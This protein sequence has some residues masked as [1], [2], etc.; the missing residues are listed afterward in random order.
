MAQRSSLRRMRTHDVTAPYLLVLILYT[1]LLL[2]GASIGC[3]CISWRTCPRDEQHVSGT[4]VDSDVQLQKRAAGRVCNEPSFGSFEPATTDDYNSKA[5][6]LPCPWMSTAAGDALDAAHAPTDSIISQ[7]S[8][9]EDTD[10]PWAQT[11]GVRD[12][13]QLHKRM[14][15]CRRDQQRHGRTSRLRKRVGWSPD[16]EWQVDWHL[17][18][19]GALVLVCTWASVPL[20]ESAGACLGEKLM[21][22]LVWCIVCAACAKMLDAWVSNILLAATAVSL[23]LVRDTTTTSDHIVSCVTTVLLVSMGPQLTPSKVSNMQLIVKGLEQTLVLTVDASDTAQH[24]RQAILHQCGI[25]PE[26][27]YLVLSGKRLQD[28]TLAACGILPSAHPPTVHM[29]FRMRGGSPPRVCRNYQLGRCRGNCSLDHP[30]KVC[31]YEAAAD[32]GCRNGLDCTYSHN[33]KDVALKRQS[34]G[35]VTKRQPQLASASTTIETSSKS[36]DEGKAVCAFFQRSECSKGDQCDY[37]HPMA[38]CNHEVEQPGASITASKCD[39]TH[40]PN[41]S[42]LPQGRAVAHPHTAGPADALAALLEA[43]MD[44][45]I[46]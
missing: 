8:R 44:K 9:R 10:A 34:Q 2:L 38:P 6:P 42:A 29:V 4:M 28:R 3:R 23:T 41:G 14:H 32:G 22:V 18:L 33:P 37:R 17:V 16:N 45:V 15:W 12:P 11:T 13:W 24:V 27:Y 31:W 5:W 21:M 36:K 20:S 30:S 19:T 46:G 26:H 35:R 39:V 7:W 40:S 43:N 1:A 25:L